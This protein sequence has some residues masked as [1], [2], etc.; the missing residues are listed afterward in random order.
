[1]NHEN[2]EDKREKRTRDFFIFRQL[3]QSE[4]IAIVFYLFMGVLA[5]GRGIFLINMPEYEVYSSDMYS[6]LDNL[7]SI[8]IWG[9]IL[10]LLSITLMLSVLL[11]KRPEFFLM[12]TS[13]ALLSVVFILLSGASLELGVSQWNF[14]VHT[15]LSSAHAILTII[16]VWFWYGQ[17]K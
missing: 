17:R 10:I 16:G 14:Y 11:P 1:M 9:I 3:R 5:G 8:D 15:S 4:A 13:N 6:E 2:K 7:M 12:V